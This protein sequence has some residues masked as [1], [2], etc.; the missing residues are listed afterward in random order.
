MRIVDLRPEDKQRINQVA[1]I[2][3]GAFKEDWPD[4]WP[5]LESATEEVRESFQ[6]DR[7]S[8]VALDG[9]GTVLGWIGGISEYDGNVWELHPL[10]VHPGHQGSGIGSA[11]VADFEEQVRQRG[12]F[13]VR[14]GSDDETNQTTLSGVDLY[15]NLWERIAKIGNL[16]RHPY[17]FYQ[18][19]GY[20]IVGVMPDANGYGKPD[21][22]MAKR[23]SSSQHEA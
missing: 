7:I 1:S 14:L 16:R 17:E 13:T 12:G 23:V 2:L 15:P 6:P 20:T 10:A 4:A 21:I 18:K 22:I 5:D 11:L 8:R 3:V 9:D 19:L